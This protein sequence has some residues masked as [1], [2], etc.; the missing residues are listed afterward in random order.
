MKRE[1]I[2]ASI[3]KKLNVEENTLND[4]LKFMEDLN[5]DSID[6]VEM[7]MEIEE[8]LNIEV[9]DEKAIKIKTIKDFIDV[10]E[11]ELNE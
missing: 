6:L 1:V 5:L 10:I 4:D 11:N 9:P 7:L 2:L 3:A 8:N